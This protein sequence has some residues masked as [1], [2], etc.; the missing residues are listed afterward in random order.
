MPAGLHL[1]PRDVTA[2]ALIGELGLLDTEMIHQRIFPSVTR[3]RCQQRLQLYQAHGFTRTVILTV[4]FGDGDQGRIPAIHCLTDRG[5]DAIHSFTGRRPARV[6]RSE[7][8]PET[9][10]HRLAIVKSRLAMDDACAAV[11]LSEP[12]WIMEQDRDPTAT[13]Q[14]PLKQRMLYHAFGDGPKI[15][16]CQPDAASLMR[17][18]RDPTRPQVNASDLLGY[19]EIDRSTESRSQ[20]LDKLPGYTTCIERHAYRRYWP[21]LKKPAVRV[22]WVCRSQ[23]RIEALCEK[24]QDASVAQLFR[25]TTAGE[26]SPETA[27]TVPIWRDLHGRCRE[28]MRV[29]P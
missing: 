16:T 15:V 1:Q 27:L 28:I 13:D 21:G 8:K 19:W 18:P 12:A 10:Y 14:P 23:R 5:A 22:F 3:R 20:I 7:P 6:L 9:F 11:G 26:L 25:F 2:L 4:W 17:I 24:L 29:S